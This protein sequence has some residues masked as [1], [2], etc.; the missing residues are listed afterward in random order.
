MNNHGYLVYGG[1]SSGCRWLTRLLIAAGCQGDG[2]HFQRMDDPAKRV[3][4]FSSGLPVVWR[5]SM[6]RAFEW[7]DPRDHITEFAKHG[8]TVQAFVIVRDWWPMSHSQ[9]LRGHVPD[10]A[11]ALANLKRAYAAVLAALHES[12]TDFYMVTYEAF[13]MNPGKSIAALMQVAGLP[14]PSEYEAPHDENLKWYEVQPVP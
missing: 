4:M 8:Y 11:S 3:A 12:Q 5:H 2:D 10:V 9:V 14:C 7:P 1:E 6:P 13:L